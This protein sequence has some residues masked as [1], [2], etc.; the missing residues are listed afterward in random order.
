[1]FMWV[2]KFLKSI[3]HESTIKYSAI[4]D[5]RFLQVPHNSCS[6]IVVLSCF[7]AIICFSIL[8]SYSFIFFILLQSYLVSPNAVSSCCILFSCGFIAVSFHCSQILFCCS[9]ILSHLVAVSSYLIAV[10]SHFIYFSSQ[11][12][13]V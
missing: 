13:L 2:R 8:L 11:F 3:C 9:F 10:L 12:Y 1:M 7:V 6:L 4:F 5:L